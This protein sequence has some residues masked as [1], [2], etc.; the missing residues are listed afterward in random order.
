MKD[1]VGDIMMVH[2]EC[3]DTQHQLIKEFYDK[4]QQELQRVP[5]KQELIDNLI[6]EPTVHELSITEESIEKYISTL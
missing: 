2:T 3:Q 1:L 5:T 6:K 4:F